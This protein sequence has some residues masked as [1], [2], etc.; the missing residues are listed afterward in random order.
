MIFLKLIFIP[1]AVF[2]II[3]RFV[4]KDVQNKSVYLIL[5]VLSALTSVV[6]LVTDFSFADIIKR[7]I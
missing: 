7:W 6:S 2:W 3:K 4:V 5:V 1:L